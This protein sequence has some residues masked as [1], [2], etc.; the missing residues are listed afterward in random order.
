MFLIKRNIL[1]R[2]NPKRRTRSIHRVVH[3]RRT[4]SK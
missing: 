1:K 2:S 4:V 3:P